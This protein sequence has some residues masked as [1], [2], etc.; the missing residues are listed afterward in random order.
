[1]K[2]KHSKTGEE[3]RFQGTALGRDADE[4]PVKIE[5]SDIESVRSWEFRMRQTPQIVKSKAVRKLSSA[6]ASGV[7]S[8]LSE[9]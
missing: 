2:K 7:S 1:M 4:K 8:P 5:G 6:H 9:P 3:S